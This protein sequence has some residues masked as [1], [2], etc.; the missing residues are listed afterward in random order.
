MALILNEGKEDWYWL[1]PNIQTTIDSIPLNSEVEFEINEDL[2]KKS[3]TFIKIKGTLGTGKQMN[4]FKCKKCGISLKDGKYEYCYTCNIAIR[5]AEENSPEGK[6]KQTSIRAQ[7]IGNMVS[8][9]LIALQGQF[10]MNNVG[11]F[12]D[13]LFNHYN[14]NIEKLENTKK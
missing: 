11:E 3:I 7:A 14:T 1:T 8:R 10:D 12:I 4:E 6:D 13:S 2:G 9:S 5:K